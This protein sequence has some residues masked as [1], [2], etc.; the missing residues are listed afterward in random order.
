MLKDVDMNRVDIVQLDFLSDFK[1]EVPEDEYTLHGFV[2]YF[3]IGF[4][5]ECKAV[6]IIPTGTEFLQQG[7]NLFRTQRHYYTL[8]AD[9]LLP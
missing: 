8:G 3:D 6:V 7:L 9:S 4:E 5:E 2:A 1:M